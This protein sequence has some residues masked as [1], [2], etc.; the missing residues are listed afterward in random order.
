MFNSF[1]III[2]SYDPNSTFDVAS[3]INKFLKD[4]LM[5]SSRKTYIHHMIKNIINCF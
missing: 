1:V 3:N 2:V 4:I 5:G